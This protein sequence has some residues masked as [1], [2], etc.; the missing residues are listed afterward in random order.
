MLR[1]LI[2]RVTRSAGRSYE[3]D[4]TISSSALAPEM[5]YRAF[6]LFR[7]MLRTR[8][9]VFLGRRVRLR[10]SRNIDFAPLTSVGDSTYVDGVGV[11]G[12]TMARGSKIGRFSTITTTSHLS[13]AGQGF[14]L[15]ARSGIGDF[16]HIGCSGGVTIGEDVIVGPFFTVHSQEHVTSDL[17]VPIRN[18]GT[19]ESAVRIGDNVWIGARVTILAGVELGNGC[20]VAAGSVVRSSFPDNSVIGGIPARLLKVRG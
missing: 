19:I 4:P 16:A 8:T 6:Q 1:Y 15:G 3:I 5:M 7:G 14:A 17:T 11:K 2:A 9:P 18:Q 20:I 12:V 10:S 13:K